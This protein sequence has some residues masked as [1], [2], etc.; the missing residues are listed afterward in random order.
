MLTT[1]IIDTG[2][3]QGGKDDGG[4]YQFSSGRQ[5]VDIKKKERYEKKKEEIV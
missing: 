4:K 2:Y 5:G 3:Q 1:L